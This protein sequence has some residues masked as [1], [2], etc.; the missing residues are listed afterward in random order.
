MTPPPPRTVILS[1]HFD[2]AALSLAGLIPRLPAPVTVVT[3]YGGAPADHHAVSWWDSTC[4]FS[5]AAEAHRTRLAED[6]RAAGLLGVDQAVLDHP[7]GPYGESDELTGIDA[8]LGAL[9]EPFPLVLLPIGTNQADH[10]RVRDRALRVLAGLGAPPPLLY[11]DLPYTGHLPEWGTP[12]VEHALGGD[13]TYGLA[14]QDL[15]ARYG[16]DVAHDLV[17]TDEE[18]A[19]KREAVL[20]YGSQLA[21]LAADHGSLVARGGPLRAERV[22]SAVR[23]PRPAGAGA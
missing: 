21:P 22:W 23:G 17:L 3:V 2:D 8:Y 13:Q 10:R 1:P 14:Y 11:A 6:A 16:L 20:C 4:G 7:D 18:W 15:R 12:D 9:P 19:R 5:T